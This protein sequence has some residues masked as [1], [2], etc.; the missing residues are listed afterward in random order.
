MAEDDKLM[1]TNGVPPE[2]P[3]YSGYAVLDTEGSGP[4]AYSFYTYWAVL[5]K[6][7]GTVFTVAFIITTLVTLVVFR[8]KPVYRATARMEVQ[9][10]TPQVQTLNELNP[11]AGTDDAFLQT[12]V[13][14]LQNNNLAWET[15]QQLG[16]AARYPGAQRCREGWA[17]EHRRGSRSNS[18]KSDSGF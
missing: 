8:M 7:R 3:G 9:A 5:K 10:E 6:R 16:L 11:S 2:R 14:L 17:S 18:S 1:A 15:I 13:D 4:E 12:Q